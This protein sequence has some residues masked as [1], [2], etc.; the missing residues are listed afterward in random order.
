[1]LTARRGSEGAILSRIVWNGTDTEQ[2][3]LLSAIER[4]CACSYDKL[5]VRLIAC[6]AHTMLVRDQRALNGLLWTRRLAKQLLAEEG[7]SAP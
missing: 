5:G 6:G 4:N 7:I 1:M 3:E 2:V